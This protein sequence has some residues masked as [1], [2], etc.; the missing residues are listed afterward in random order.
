VI[1]ARSPGGGLARRHGR[2]AGRSRSGARPHAADAFTLIELLVV[3]AIIAL[4]IGLLLPAVQ[5]ARESARRAACGNNLRQLGIAWQAHAAAHDAYPGGGWGW[6]WIGD[7]DRGRGRD[8]PGGWVYNTLD[9]LEQ[10]TLRQ[11]GAGQTDPARKRAALT[12]LATVP[13][14]VLHCPSRRPASITAVKPHWRP[15]NANF[16]GMVAKSDYAANLGDCDFPDIADPSSYA[17]GDNQAWWNE[18]V[19]KSRLAKL[20]GLAAWGNTVVPAH[21]RDGTSNTY[22]VGEKSLNPDSYGGVGESGSATYDLGDN[23]VAYTGFNR[24][25]VRSANWP[26]RRDT[27][28]LN[29]GMH[30]GSAHH[31]GFAMCFADGAVRWLPYTLDPLVH[32]RLAVRNDGNPVSPDGL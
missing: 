31:G 30:F 6:D 17:T 7:P 23:E 1:A 14:Q 11:L 10:T 13:L 29:T 20:N 18:P 21:V 16:T 28:G 2:A 5:T 4:L 27:P 32:R 9:F 25:I 12:Q 15:P 8:Q 24:D 19:Q 26:P 22:L 3:I